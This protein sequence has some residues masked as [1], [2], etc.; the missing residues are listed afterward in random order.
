MRVGVYKDIETR[1]TESNQRKSQNLQ[2]L[3]QQAQ[4]QDILSDSKSKSQ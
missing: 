4:L 2:M 1:T 3:K